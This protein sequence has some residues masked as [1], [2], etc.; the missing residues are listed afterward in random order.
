MM[1]DGGAQFP[2]VD[3]LGVDSTGAVLLAHTIYGL[4]K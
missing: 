2:I 4:V 3:G 1:P